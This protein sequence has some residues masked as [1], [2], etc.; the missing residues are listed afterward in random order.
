MVVL[1]LAFIT[2]VSYGTI[3]YAFSVLLGDGAVAGELGRALPSG[4]LALGVLVSGA[5]APLV[6]TVCDVLGSRRVFLAGAVLGG[7]GL[8]AFLETVLQ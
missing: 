4:A 1:S 8:A 5:L 7:A 2:T 3:L 6:G